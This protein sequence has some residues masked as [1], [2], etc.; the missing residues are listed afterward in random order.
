[1]SL[2]LINL[3]LITVKIRLRHG[4]IYLFGNARLLD[5]PLALQMST[6]V[7]SSSD[8]KRAH[9][10]HQT[11]IPDQYRTQ[12]QQLQEFFPAWSVDGLSLKAFNPR[13]LVYRAP[14]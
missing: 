10:P 4:S 9:L 14:P 6:T 3:F 11:K 13:V 2:S 1:V 12:V 5:T 7:K 8:P